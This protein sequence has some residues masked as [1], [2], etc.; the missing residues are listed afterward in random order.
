M[1]KDIRLLVSL[2]DIDNLLEDASDQGDA[3]ELKSLGFAL[4]SLEE[5]KNARVRVRA[6]VDQAHVRA[7]DRL[8]GVYR[9]RSVVPIVNGTCSGCFGTLPTARLQEAKIG[10][11]VLCCEN[12]GR[13]LFWM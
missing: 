9:R 4:G 1:N 5:L 8:S 13:I 11:K 3:H 2:Q 6:A 12:C 10:D 7:Y